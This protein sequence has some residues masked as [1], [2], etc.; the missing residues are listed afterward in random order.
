[1]A[2]AFVPKPVPA[3]GRH[4]LLGGDDS[5]LRLDLA[6]AP[7]GAVGLGPVAGGEP[8]PLVMLQLGD[9]VVEAVDLAP[10][11]GDFLGAAAIAGLIDA[12]DL[13][14]GVPADSS[15][16]ARLRI[17]AI[18]PVAWRNSA[19]AVASRDVR[20]WTSFFSASVSLW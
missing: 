2:H 7:D 12:G 13:Q 19:V 16:S 11:A 3:F 8:D 6:D 4:A 15:V 5:V 1:M 9:L 20:D 14:A 17:A 10:Q 18:S